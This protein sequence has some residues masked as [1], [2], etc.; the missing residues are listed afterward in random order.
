MS[1][2]QIGTAIAKW[3][4]DEDL[5]NAEG[6]DSPIYLKYDPWYWFLPYFKREDVVV[7]CAAGNTASAPEDWWVEFPRRHAHQG[8]VG[9]DSLIVVGGTDQEGKLWKEDRGGTNRFFSIITAYAPGSQMTCADPSDIDAVQQQ[10]GTS[11]S[12]ALVSGLIATFLD[13]ADLQATLQVPGSVAAHV[14]SFVKDAAQHH[15]D[16]SAIDPDAGAPLNVLGTHNYV[17][18]DTPA[19]S[20]PGGQVPSIGNTFAVRRGDTFYNPGVS[21]TDLF[22]LH[23]S[24]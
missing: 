7:V 23:P 21:W 12:T 2:H 20:F 11:C 18:C 19:T 6:V 4:D 17:P 9:E 13:R 14:K 5:D 8:F 3:A 22:R 10:A 15:T 16:Q 1:C 24:R